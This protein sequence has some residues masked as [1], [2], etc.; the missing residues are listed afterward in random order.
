MGELFVVWSKPADHRNEGDKH[1]D[2]REWA[3]AEAAYKKH[4]ASHSD[5]IDI[6]V[7]YGHMLKE[8]KKL[9]EAEAA[10]STAVSLRPDDADA[11]VHLGHVQKRQGK[12]VAAFAAFNRAQELSPDDELEEEMRSLRRQVEKAPDAAVQ[13]GSIMF[14]VQD[15]VEFLKTYVTMSGIQR[16][17]AGIARSA[18]EIHGLDAHFI[19][20]DNTGI[21]EPGVFWDIQHQDLRALID[22]ASS[23]SVQR[24]EL[25]RLVSLCEER[26]S[27]VTPGAGHTVVILGCFWSHEN[28]ADRYFASKRAGARISAYIYDIIPI[29]HP[30]FCDA[31]LVRAFTNSLS[32]LCLIA[33]FFLTISDYTR[34]VLDSFFEAQGS[35]AIPMMTVPLA[36]S[37]TGTS[38]MVSSWPTVLQKIRGREYVSFVST[39]EGRKNHLYVVNV[40]RQLM[41]EGKSVPDLVFV[42]RKGWRINGLMDL[43]EGTNH[44]DG[45]VHIVHDLSDAELNGVYENSLFTVFTSFVEG[46]GLPVGESLMHGKMCVASSTSSIPEVGGDFVD[47][48]DP[49]NLQ[50]G[51]AVIGRLLDDRT[52]LAERQKNIVDNFKPRGWDDVA[53]TFVDNVR[54]LGAASLTPMAYPRLRE[55]WYFRPGDL[56]RASLALVPYSTKATRLLIA[57]S[58]YHQEHFGAWMRGR[59]GEI[60]FQTDLAEGQRVIVYMEFLASDWSNGCSLLASIQTPPD[61]QPARPMSI[62][63]AAH[64]RLKISVQGQVGAG[65]LCRLCV[66]ILGDYVSP[67]YE[68][69]DF[70]VGLCGIGY[71]SHDNLSARSDIY[72]SIAFQPATYLA[73]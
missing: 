64:E 12:L 72:E 30:E 49:Q 41:A 3:L 33:D 71:A 24:T 59:F 69:R 55:G 63:L 10:Y 13:T 44:L 14:S 17:Q 52:Y 23:P 43:L 5:D 29:S 45:R 34:D 54:T 67:E 50:E 51:I 65:G 40:W 42:G 73:P 66:E 2:A 70:V 57:T 39:V 68:S 56:T 4:L 38:E 6:W 22:Y 18:M 1:R 20:T 37:L 47:Y 31:G 11:N 36:H 16:V 25:R 62:R 48:I 58:F 35:R 7:Q 28:T 15:L 9:A 61:E 60:E 19:L 21:L 46:W 53:N 26:A 27:V 8:S 32:E